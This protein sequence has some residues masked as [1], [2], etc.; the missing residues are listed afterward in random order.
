MNPRNG[1]GSA[2]RKSANNKKYA[3]N[4]DRIFGNKEDTKK[5]NKE[6]KK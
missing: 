1:K 2:P 3:N 4:W 5:E 6:S